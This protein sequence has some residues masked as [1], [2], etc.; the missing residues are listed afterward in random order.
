[1]GLPKSWREDIRVYADKVPEYLAH[2]LCMLERIGMGN[3]GLQ[4][5]KEHFKCTRSHT[6]LIRSGNL[7]AY[8]VHCSDVYREIL[9]R[10]DTDD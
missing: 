3:E 9:T 6:G 8:P 5:L 4:L 7:N 1:M 2:R 10:R